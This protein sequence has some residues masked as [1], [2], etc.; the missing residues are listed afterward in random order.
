MF[1]LIFKME[2]EERCG[3]QNLSYTQFL[4]HPIGGIWRGE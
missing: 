2:R 4:L 3:E 1:G